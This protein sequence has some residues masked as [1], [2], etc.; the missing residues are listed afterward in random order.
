VASNSQTYQGRSLNNTTHERIPQQNVFGKK[1]INKLI[2]KKDWWGCRYL[3]FATWGDTKKGKTIKI[4]HAW[5]LSTPGKLV[6]KRNAA[7]NQ[8]K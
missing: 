5:K 7:E 3:S 2:R 6:K 1:A 8:Q 4:A